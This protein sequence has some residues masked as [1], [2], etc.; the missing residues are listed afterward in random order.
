MTEIFG[1]EHGNNAKR[2][3]DA[4]SPSL[5]TIKELSGNSVIAA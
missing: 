4:L 3:H 2:A 5:T 1:T